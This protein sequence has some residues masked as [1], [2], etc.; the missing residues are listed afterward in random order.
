MVVDR[1]DGRILGATL[2]GY[3]SAELVHV[4][5]AHIARGSTWHDLSPTRCTSIRPLP[6][7]CRRSR[8]WSPRSSMPALELDRTLCGDLALAEAREW[9][10]TNG[11]GGFAAGTVAGTLTRRYHGLLFA[12]R[13]PPVGRTLLCAKIDAE[14]EYDGATYPLA[15]DR[16]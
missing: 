3:E 14:V 12:A 16:W 2:V 13:T 11:L 7:G 10:V 8:A 4:F 9:I 6:K 1:R 5:V 15:T